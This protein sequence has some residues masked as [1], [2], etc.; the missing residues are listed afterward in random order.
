VIE[1]ADGHPAQDERSAALPGVKGALIPDRVRGPQEFQGSVVREDA[2]W[3]SDRR[4]Q[5]GGRV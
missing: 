5:D 1:E 4:Y 2:V 3:P